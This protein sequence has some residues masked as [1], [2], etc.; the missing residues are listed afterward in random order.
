MYSMLTFL[1]ISSSMWAQVTE[2]ERPASWNQLVEGGRFADRFLPMPDGKLSSDTWGAQQVIPRFIDNGIED[3][4]RSYWGG[5]ILKGDDGK[6]H[7][8][9]CGWREDSPK[10]HYEWPNSIVYHT[11]SDNRF[12]PYHIQDTIGPGHNPEAF[13]TRSG[14]YV[15]Y[16]IDHYYLADNINGP[17]T[18]RTFD[19]DPRDRKIIEGLSNLTFTQRE[20]GSY[21]MICRGGGVWISQTGLSTYNQIS[22]QRIYPPV[23]GEFEDPVV[24]RDSV[25][26]NAIVNDWLGRVAFYLRSKDGVK[27]VTDPGEAYMPGIAVHKDGTKEDWF[28]YERIKIFQDEQERAIQANFA[29]IDTLKNEDKPNIAPRTSAF[30]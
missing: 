21:L 11:V 16:V 4:V 1:C 26:Y 8:F 28:K 14:K 20:D 7:L 22:D 18:R 5:N 10:G 23:E 19:F 6:Y 3:Q 15:I 27:W 29:V 17:W 30:R 13:K 2:R 9:V 24:W 25:Q 12:G